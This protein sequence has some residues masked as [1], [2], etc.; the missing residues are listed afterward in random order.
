M[1]NVTDEPGA[2]RH[3]T[4]NVTDD[5]KKNLGK[6]VFVTMSRLNTPGRGTPLFSS[7]SSS[8]IGMPRYSLLATNHGL[9]HIYNFT[10]LHFLAVSNTS[11][12][13]PTLSLLC[14]LCLSAVKFP[15][16]DLEM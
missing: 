16:S 9:L 3:V 6:T 11:L 15:T 14:M 8:P 2:S 12:H 5:L 4:D 10:F 7:S 1:R 13:S